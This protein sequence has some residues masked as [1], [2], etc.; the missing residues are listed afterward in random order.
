M[1]SAAP[2]TNIFAANP[3]LGL[4]V[5]RNLNLD[6]GQPITGRAIVQATATLTAAT[7][8]ARYARP[9][10]TVTATD[11]WG[12]PWRGVRSRPLSHGTWG[13]HDD[14]GTSPC[15]AQ[16]PSTALPA[17]PSPAPAPTVPARTTP[18]FY[19]VTSSASKRYPA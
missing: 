17:G 8:L 5:G 14:C 2:A 13:Q 18:T 1:A 7:A 10:W 3:L 19:Q 16:G 6:H 11:G 12:L 4:R 15:C 9:G